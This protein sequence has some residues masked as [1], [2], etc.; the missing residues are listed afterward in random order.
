LAYEKKIKVAIG[1]AAMM[2][3]IDFVLE[4]LNIRKYFPALISADDV[5]RS[6][7][8][9][10]TFIKC[11]AALGIVPADCLVFED[12]TKDVEAAMNAKMKAVVI[13]LMNEKKDFNTYH[14]V[15]YFI[16]DFSDKN[17]RELIV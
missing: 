11:A 13:T 7:P 2:F 12:G 15:T 8:D 9:P 4:G 1:S 17:L 3:N 10:E 14:N 6:K 5:I 16:E